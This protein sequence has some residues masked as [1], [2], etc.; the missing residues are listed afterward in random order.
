MFLD[1]AIYVPIIEVLPIF[2]VAIFRRDLFNFEKYLQ[3]KSEK[4]SKS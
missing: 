3:I 4:N 2:G 1:I